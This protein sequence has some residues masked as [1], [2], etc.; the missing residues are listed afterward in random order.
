MS[1]NQ[2]LN[3]PIIEALPSKCESILD[4]GCGWGMTALLLKIQ[5]NYK[6][7]IDGL[8]IHEPWIEHLKKLNLYDNV[9][10]DTALNIEKYAS[11]NKYDLI[12]CMELI[13]HLTRKEGLYL[14]DKLKELATTVIITTP[15]TPVKTLKIRR[16]KHHTGNETMKHQSG[17]TIADFKGYDTK[18]VLVHYIPW[19]FKPIY[20]LRSKVLKTSLVFEN[21]IAVHS[22]IPSATKEEATAT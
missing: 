21:I 8:D 19:Y 20:W 11:N 16:R 6:G 9:Y 17:Y 7:I 2:Y 15:K 3:Q 1:H 10:C 12:I 18:T 14:I 22:T 5:E 4:L 13:E